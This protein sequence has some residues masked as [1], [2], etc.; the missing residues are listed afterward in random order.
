[1]QNKTTRK[2]LPNYSVEDKCFCRLGLIMLPII[3]RATPPGLAGD[4]ENL[5]KKNDHLHPSDQ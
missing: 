2:P 3:R 1:M 5:N 4:N